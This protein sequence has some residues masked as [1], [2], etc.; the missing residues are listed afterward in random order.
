MFAT[1][2]T[3]SSTGTRRA[4]GCT[5]WAWKNYKGPGMAVNTLMIDGKMTTAPD[6]HT[7]LQAAREIGI[8]I[9]TL[10]HLEGASE[11][12]AC[13]VCLVEIVGSNRLQP[14]CL[15]KVGEGMEV[16]TA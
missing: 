6:G 3:R 2:T 7:I 1:S 9:P 4:T 12:G 5:P 14:S 8:D 10:C 13:R 16:H 11:A 15:T